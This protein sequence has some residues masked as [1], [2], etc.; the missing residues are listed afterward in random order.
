MKYKIPAVLPLIL[1]LLL[2]GELGAAQDNYVVL[3]QSLGAFKSAFNAD[4]GKLRLVMYVAPTCGGCLRGA[5]LSQQE[6]LAEIDNPELAAYVVWVPKNG[7]REEHVDRV[8]DLVT[9]E[10][11]SQYWDAEGAATRAYDVMFE[12]E[13]RPCAGVFMLY[14]SDAFWD[15]E[16][17]PV[18][19]YFE[20]A[21]ARE[22]KQKAG[23][24]FDAGRL[25]DHAR[26]L[27]GES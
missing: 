17:P 23:A 22:F 21:H 26:R 14:A 18:P 2:A 16:S 6:L 8:L 10:R 27:L 20:D 25:A 11:S 12:I 4:R 7:A 5:K 3:D 15:G 13:G 19:V 1:T 24:Q 9:D